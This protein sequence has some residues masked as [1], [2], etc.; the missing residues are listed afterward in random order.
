[1]KIDTAQHSKI[2][3]DERLTNFQLFIWCGLHCSVNHVELLG[4]AH[5]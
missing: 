4:V 2:L 5:F 3:V 1:M